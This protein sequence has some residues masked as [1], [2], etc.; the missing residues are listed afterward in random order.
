MFVVLVVR[1]L[2]TK[3]QHR[4]AKRRGR[5]NTS[6]CALR[7]LRAAKYIPRSCGLQHIHRGRGPQHLQAMH[8]HVEAIDYM[9]A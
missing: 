7:P 4:L 5:A 9:L 1:T 8:D 3:S 2:S 6:L